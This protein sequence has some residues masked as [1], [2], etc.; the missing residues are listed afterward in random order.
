MMMINDNARFMMKVLT[1]LYD[2]RDDKKFADIIYKTYSKLDPEKIRKKIQT[3]HNIIVNLSK[4]IRD[5]E[6]ELSDDDID[7]IVDECRDRVNASVI[8]NI[9]DNAFDAMTSDGDMASIVKNCE[10]F[11]KA[12]VINAFCSNY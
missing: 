11:N 6:G 4:A 9:R 2:R 1:A 12:N 10:V 5:T 7:E 8:Q 3:H